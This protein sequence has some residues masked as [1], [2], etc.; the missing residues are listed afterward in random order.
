MR[1]VSFN[2]NNSLSLHKF[3]YKYSK[4]KKDIVFWKRKGKQTN[5]RAKALICQSSKIYV[6]EV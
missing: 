6:M 3:L 2:L 1:Y 4:R 5:A